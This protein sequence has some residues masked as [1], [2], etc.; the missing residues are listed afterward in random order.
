MAQQQQA[1][2]PH[3]FIEKNIPNCSKNGDKKSM[4]FPTLLELKIDSQNSMKPAGKS[5][6]D[7]VEICCNSKDAREVDD[8]TVDVETNK[9]VLDGGTSES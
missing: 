5:K 8:C 6:A 9:F 3:K 4:G 2:S 7:S 1:K